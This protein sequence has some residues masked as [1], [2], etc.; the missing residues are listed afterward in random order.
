MNSKEIGAFYEKKAV[1]F[2][3]KKGYKIIE[4]N[5]QNKY[6][7]LDIICYDKTDTLV[8]CEVKYRSSLLYGTPYD[9]I[10]NKKI[11]NI[12]KTTVGY[13]REHKISFEQLCR[14]DVVVIFNDENNEKIEHIEHA[15]EFII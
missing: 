15:F 3:K 6:G 9:T 12:C 1:K 2:L 5:Y 13:Y 4:R 11:K 10:T 7:E 8:I 14:F